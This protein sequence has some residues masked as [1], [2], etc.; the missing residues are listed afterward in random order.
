MMTKKGDVNEHDSGDDQHND[1][2]AVENDNSNDNN[3]AIDIDSNN[4]SDGSNDT[5]ASLSVGWQQA[6]CEQA[7]FLPPRSPVGI[8][9]TQSDSAISGQE[10]TSEQRLFYGAHI[11]SETRNVEFKRGGGE[12]H[13]SIFFV[14]SHFTLT[15]C[16]CV[17]LMP[18][19]ANLLNT[20]AFCFHLKVC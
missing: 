13:L 15:V 20:F 2:A 1:A 4:N 6:A 14:Y 18:I 11:G 9:G 16:V 8:A 5:D 3:D 7:A 10:I 12:F 17:C 19:A